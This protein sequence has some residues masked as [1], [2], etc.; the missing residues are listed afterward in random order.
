MRR[1]LERAL[2]PDTHARQLRSVESTPG[3]GVVRPEGF[4]IRN[5]LLCAFGL[6]GVGACA[7]WL[8]WYGVHL[9]HRLTTEEIR[10]ACARTFPETI[11]RCVDTVIIQR[12]GAR[13]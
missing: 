2:L 12:G 11:E 5:V 1:N 9:D 4:I 13:R 10:G 3:D 8:V 7:T 6:I